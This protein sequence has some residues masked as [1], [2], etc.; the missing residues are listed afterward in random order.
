MLKLNVE[1]YIIQKTKMII[2][3]NNIYKDIAF[4][5]HFYQ[6]LN[7]TLNSVPAILS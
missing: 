5:V 6:M 2:D 7:F 4:L 1:N 3:F